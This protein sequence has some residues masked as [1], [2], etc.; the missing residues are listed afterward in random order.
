MDKITI[1]NNL[2]FKKNNQFEYT[3]SGCIIS[4]YSEI[5]NLLNIVD[6]NQITKFCYFNRKGIHSILYIEQEIIVINKPNGLSYFFYLSLLINE[7]KEIIN[8]S[9]SYDLIKD[10]DAKNENN[11]FLIRLITSKII[12]ELINNFEG[13]DN[14]ENETYN[15]EIEKLKKNNEDYIKNNVINFQEYHLNYNY[16]D[17]I[18]NKIDYIYIDIIISL[19][20]ERKFEEYDYMYDIIK[21]LDLENIDIT[22]TMHME[23]SLVLNSNESYVTD[24][25]ITEVEDLK[26]AKKVNFYYILFKYILKNPIYIYNIEMLLNTRKNIIKIIKKK[27]NELSSLI[28]DNDVIKKRKEYILKEL[29]DSDYYYNKVLIY[30]KSKNNEINLNENNIKDNNEK[31]N[32][33]DSKDLKD[34]EKYKEKLPIINHFYNIDNKDNDNIEKFRSWDN[35]EEMI[36]EKKI[37]NMQKSDKE[38]LFTYCSDNN[39]ELF[40]KIFNEDVYE[41]ILKEKEKAINNMNKIKEILSYYK[42]YYP[43][44]KK[45]EI[46]ELE[47]IISNNLEIPEKYLND[48]DK[49]KRMNIMTPFITYFLERENKPHSEKEINNFVDEFEIAKNHLKSNKFTKMQKDKKNIMITLIENYKELALSIFSQEEI[50]NFMSKVNAQKEVQRKNEEKLKI[51][52]TNDYQSNTDKKMPYDDT[53]S[54][55]DKSNKQNMRENQYINPSIENQSSRIATS[56]V[57]KNGSITMN[58]QTKSVGIKSNTINNDNSM[59]SK[60][61]YKDIV[62]LVMNIQ[63]KFILQVKVKKKEKPDVSYEDLSYEDNKNNTLYLTYKSMYD[64]KNEFCN[65]LKDKISEQEQIFISYI[66]FLDEIKSR[67]QDEYTNNF[68]FKLEIEFDKDNISAVYTF[69]YPNTNGKEE[70]LKFKED[71]FLKYKTNSMTQAF[72]YLIEEINDEEYTIRTETSI[73]DSKTINSQTNNNNNTSKNENNLSVTVSPNQSVS[74]NA[75]KN[76]NNLSVTVSPNQ[77]VSL[78]ALKNEN[79]LSTTVSLNQ[80][81]ST[82]ASNLSKTNF[83]NN[84][85]SISQDYNIFPNKIQVI[86]FVKILGSHEEKKNICSSEYIKELSNGFFVSA[87]TDS[88]IIVYNKNFEI[89]EEIIT[90]KEWTYS[91]CERLISK[92]E[93]IVQ[94]IGCSNKELFLTEINLKDERCIKAQKYELPE[95]TSTNCIEMRANDYVIVGL[96]GA[97]FYTNLFEQGKHKVQNH[98]I[99]DKTYRGVI[100]IGK[101]LAVMTSNSVS[102]NGEDSLIFYDCSEITKETKEGKDSKNKKNKSEKKNNDKIF[103]LYSNKDKYSFTFN[104]VGLALINF[105]ENENENEKKN[106]KKKEKKKKKKKKMKIK[107]TSKKEMIINI[108]KIKF[109]SVLAKNI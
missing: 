18:N 55:D 42:Y 4:K 108:M 75:S 33:N 51:S 40:V 102:V 81:A 7:D 93:G 91:I 78:N 100:K 22:K 29:I 43:E 24:Y 38:K 2:F 106:K 98:V 5:E 67:I 41:Y 1:V 87:G 68:N 17:I 21:L 48:Y 95:T 105:K 80:S 96:N 89:H 70:K 107:Q 94:F 19:I 65:N 74:I 46:T 63:K 50:D 84:S 88:K 31:I 57:S 85:Q 20:K 25:I 35:L 61:K 101:D 9:Y 11:N 39:K 8:Y 6:I 47:K 82:N 26:N 86:E 90:I 76:E 99:T 53:K 16:D 77:S 15:E 103:E 97:H 10:L 72:Q 37:E 32:I 92:K 62:G 104:N 45:K 27:L 3:D 64:I 44:S 52:N 28:F 54:I 49:S 69:Y 73:K 23:L 14:P 79:N 83:S 56:I 58:Y 71:D 60:T 66:Q 12:L 59:E 109:Y 30:N 13:L 34:E 36:K